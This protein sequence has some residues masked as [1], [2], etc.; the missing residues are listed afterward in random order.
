MAANND[1]NSGNDPRG[2]RPY[3]P[4]ARVPIPQQPAM[5]AADWRAVGDLAGAYRNWLSGLARNEQRGTRPGG[6][7]GGRGRRRPGG[8]GVTRTQSRQSAMA[9]IMD[10]LEPRGLAS[11]AEW[12]WSRWK[13]LGGATNRGA[14]DV[15]KVEMTQRQE[16]KDRFPAYDYFV[17]QGNAMSLDAII[18]Y[19]SQAKQVLN[20][21]GADTA[22]SNQDIQKIMMGGV[23]F[24]ELQE[25]VGM[26]RQAAD[27]PVGMAAELQ[28]LYNVDK[29]LLARF[30]LDPERTMPDINRMWEAGQISARSL[31]AGFGGMSVAD[32]ERIANATSPEE[33]AQRMDMAA[34][35]RGLFGNQVG[36]SVGLG[37][38]DLVGFVAGEAGATRRVGDRSAARRAAY[39][40]GSGFRAGN[41]GVV[42]LG[43]SG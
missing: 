39:Q 20:T 15:I 41:A 23:S 35:S 1:G 29:N 28:R 34:Q 5:T 12:A 32:A 42:G 27:S 25:R 43:E 24:N 13:D 10:F 19:E 11:L 18:A 36:D 3:Q 6:G 16:F 17:K 30:W 2:E 40:G 8:G 21:I 4:P 9:L 31:D 37:G 7:G 38:D 33:A 26:A 22:Y 14:F